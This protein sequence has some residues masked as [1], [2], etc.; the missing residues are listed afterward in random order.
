MLF[1]YSDLQFVSHYFQKFVEIISK[2][3]LSK[4]IFLPYRYISIYT[5]Y[6]NNRR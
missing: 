3:T 5:A 6:E 4:F 2:F 1:I